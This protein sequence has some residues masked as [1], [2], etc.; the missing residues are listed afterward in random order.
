MD[1]DKPKLV[2]SLKQLLKNLKKEREMAQREK[3]LGLKKDLVFWRLKNKQVHFESKSKDQFS[4]NTCF[5]LFSFKSLNNGKHQNSTHRETTIVGNLRE[6]NFMD[7]SN[8]SYFDNIL[9]TIPEI[10]WIHWWTERI[11]DLSALSI[12]MHL[13]CDAFVSWNLLPCIIIK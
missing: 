13:F 2:V 9:L 3:F 4:M 12:C 8:K 5:E 7:L 1:F 11:L 10:N 6:T